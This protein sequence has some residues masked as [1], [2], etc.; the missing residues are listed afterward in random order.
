MYVFLSFAFI[1]PFDIY[2]H[3]IM[4]PKVYHTDNSFLFFFIFIHFKLQI[5]S[6]LFQLVIN[7]LIYKN[8]F[9]VQSM[10]EEAPYCLYWLNVEPATALAWYF[11]SSYNQLPDLEFLPT[12]LSQDK[13]LQHLH[14][15]AAESFWMA[16]TEQ[17]HA[18]LEYH[19]MLV[20]LYHHQVHS[21]LWNQH[22]QHQQWW[23]T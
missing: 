8:S 10:V 6:Y 18:G 1:L 12:L 23:L 14:Y 9:I 7:L 21:W 2:T 11:C 17:C 3:K 5:C 13:L 22:Y 4:A 19:W 15:A 16:Q 20:V